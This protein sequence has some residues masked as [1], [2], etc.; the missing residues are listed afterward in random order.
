MTT[1]SLPCLGTLTVMGVMLPS[2]CSE[3]RARVFNCMGGNGGCEGGSKG[4]GDRQEAGVGIQ[5]RKFE[6]VL[7]DGEGLSESQQD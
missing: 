5:E 6:E 3:V 4:I 1:V 2:L 7:W